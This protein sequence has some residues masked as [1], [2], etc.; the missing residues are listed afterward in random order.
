MATQSASSLIHDG[1]AVP[2]A[3]PKAELVAMPCPLPEMVP[4][5][6]WSTQGQRQMAANSYWWLCAS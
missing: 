3:T 1:S 6:L 4:T 2:L 5:V